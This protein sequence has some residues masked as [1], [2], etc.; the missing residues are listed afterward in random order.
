MT[1]DQKIAKLGKEITDR[2]TVLLGKDKIT[3]NSPEY[4]G[5]NSALKYT[6][7]KYDQKMA[8]DILDICLTMKKRVPLTIEQ[9]AAKNPQFDR[10]YLEKAMQA[11]SESGLVEFHWENL[12]G[13]NPNHEKRWVLDMF[14]PGSAEIMMINPEQSDM[15][16][17]T[18]DF[19]ERMAYL[20]LAGITELVPPGGAGIGMHV[21]PVEKAIP[22]E[23]KSLPIEHLS[24]WLKKYEGHIGVSVCSCRKQ[25]RIRGEGS[26]DIEGEWCIGVG[27]FADYCR[28][29]NHGRDITYE[30]A[31]EI[32][33]KAEDKGYVHQITNIDGENKIFGI[34]NCA[35]GVCNALRTSQL[36]NTPNLSASAY[37][38]ES[39]P[40]KCVACGKCVETCPAGAVRLGQKLC[41]KEGPIQY[42]HHEL[43][44]DTQWG[45]DHWNKN[46]KN[47]NGSIQTWPTGTAPCKV[48]CPAHIAIQGYIKMAADGRYADAL[49]LIKKDNP[50]P[51]VCGSICRKYCEDACTRGT[52]DEPLQIDEIKKFIAEQDMKA[53]HRYVP[54]M[55]SCTHEKFDQ[56][57]AIIGAGPAG[58]SCAYYLAEMGYA[59]VTV[60]DR[61][62]VPGGMLTLGIPSFR[63]ERKVINAEID[64][65]KKMGVKFKCGVEVGKDITIDELR[66]QG[67]K[68]FFV[69]IGAQKSAK[70][71]ITGEELKGVYGGVD[72]L[73]DVNLGNK[74]EIGKKVAVIGGGN[75]A[76][77][78][79]RTAV[80]L[81]A[82][83]A[84]I[85]YRRSEDEMPADKEE[86]AEAMAEGVKFC[87]LNAPVEITGTAAGKVNG[88]K[89][90]IMELGEPDEK[91]RRKPVGT[92][93]FKTI[94]VNSVIGAIGQTI[95]WG[96]LDIGALK[97]AAKGVAMAD[98]VTLQTA[99]ED[100]FVGGDCYTG[101]KFAI[102]AIAAGREGAIS[103]HRYV[104]P[105]QS[106]TLAR[107]P[108]DFYELDKDNVV[109][110][111]NCFDAP[112]RQEVKHDP[113]KAKTMKNDRVTFTEEQVKAEASRC[114]GCGV[115]IVDQNKCIGCGLCTTRCE[116]D[117]IR[118]HRDHP[119]AS[120]MVR[121]DDKIPP[122]AAYAA[123]RAVKIKIKDL[124]EK[125]AK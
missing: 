36:F 19:F 81:G 57:I 99:Q 7:Y 13:K 115:T 98:P 124:K 113:R 29:T 88:L 17:E 71:G 56:K 18:A 104:Q 106:L 91:G 23:S 110:D 54:P 107:N 87:Y 74:V 80:R 89:V 50:F 60:F 52:V 16:P 10:A 37:T 121:T 95:D 84:Y 83:E 96:E 123:K 6:A 31:I 85:V 90:E 92:G 101:P 97:T 53:E 35:V 82:E 58:M 118:L 28:E 114:L 78:V 105:G 21:I 2:A 64:V 34:C 45:E 11:V 48:A 68:G 117:A 24:H 51:A 33:Q 49:K 62:P 120:K 43:P 63:L 25:Q 59:N 94:K 3:P 4:L 5:I 12:D 73:R 14:V 40:E 27:D 1:K 55:V 44:D 42:P 103:L 26:G 93:K 15:Y 86:V 69:A 76:M 39:D 116:F 77:D 61:N 67:Y 122:L 102:D 32:L 30:E 111:I 8:D 70:L 112:V 22:A 75:V 46:Y 66:K 47:E 79:V 20:P 9:L 125:L 100:I 119:D 109:L 108:R 65:L 38:A 72:F 41:T